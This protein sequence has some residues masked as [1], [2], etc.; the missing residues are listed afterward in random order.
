MRMLIIPAIDL[1]DGKVVRLKQGIFNQKTIYSSDPVNTA[2]HWERQGAEYLHVV[3]LDGAKTGNVCHLDVI[4]RIAKSVKIPIEFGGGLRQKKSIKQVLACGV[5]RAVLGTKLQDEDFLRRVF[6]EFKQRIIISIDA[7]DNIVRVKGW[8]RE[9]SALS[10]LA[11][12]RR[13]EDMG[14][15]QIIYTDITRDGTLKG[16]NIVMIKRIL[17]DSGLSIIAS[18]GISSLA[19]LFKLKALSSR[20]LAGVIVGKALYEG[21]FT[22]RE[23]LKKIR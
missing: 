21:R 9:C 14:F 4:R 1:K 16:P 15:Q 10:I 19:D 5:K 3:D 2:R 11:L 20:G 13:L 17:K 23:A 18:G 22:L 7:R 8:Q 6:K 12:V